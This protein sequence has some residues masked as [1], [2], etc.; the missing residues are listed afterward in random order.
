MNDQNTPSPDQKEVF[1]YDPNS[2][3]QGQLIKTVTVELDENENHPCSEFF[4]N[5][6][7]FE[8]PEED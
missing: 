8:K 3:K 5:D 7:N 6:E 4:R 1:T 2:R